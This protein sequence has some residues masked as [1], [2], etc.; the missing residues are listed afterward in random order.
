MYWKRL[1]RRD[2]LFLTIRQSP[3]CLFFHILE[4]EKKKKSFKGRQQEKFLDSF[5]CSQVKKIWAHKWI[6]PFCWRSEDGEKHDHRHWS[7]IH[8]LVVCGYLYTFMHKH[9]RTQA[10]VYTHTCTWLHTQIHA[11]ITHAQTHV[12]TYPHMHA[13]V[14]M[15][16]HTH[17]TDS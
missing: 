13:Q 12:H 1:G 16:A 4:R 2:N 7:E 3:F 15:H 11:C 5:S 8:L 14:H 6:H 9:M 17:Y 10:H